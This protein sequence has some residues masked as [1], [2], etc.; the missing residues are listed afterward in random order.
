MSIR[1]RGG[2]RTRRMG[3]AASV[4]AIVL[5]IAGCGTDNGGSGTPGGGGKTTGNQAGNEFT[6]PDIPMYNGPVGAG[7]GE[8][9]V[10]AWPGYAESG[11]NDPK[12]DWVTPFE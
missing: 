4:G 7:E 9:N 10:L 11:K 1:H 5:I 12:V 2:R 6:P 8:L 3:V